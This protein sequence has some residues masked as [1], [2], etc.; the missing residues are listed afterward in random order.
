MFN[1]FVFY[2]RI[3]NNRDLLLHCTF[4]SLNTLYMSFNTLYSVQKNIPDIFN[5]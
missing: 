2:K 4:M 1:D 5:Q 3:D